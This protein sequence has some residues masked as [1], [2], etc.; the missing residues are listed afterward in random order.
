MTL[1][2][3]GQ[4]T[5]ILADARYNETLLVQS[6][7]NNEASLP[8]I[9]TT[10]S[11][12][13][14]RTPSP[15]SVGGHNLDDIVP[16]SEIIDSLSERREPNGKTY[17]IDGNGSKSFENYEEANAVAL[18]DDA[19]SMAELTDIEI[20][21]SSEQS[22]VTAQ[23][24]PQ[25]MEVYD[26]ETENAILQNN[27]VSDDIVRKENQISSFV[28]P[29][30]I[31]YETT[32]KKD[33]PVILSD[34]TV[35]EDENKSESAENEEKNKADLI[36]NK[37]ENTK[38]DLIIVNEPEE[39]KNDES[40]L[41]EIEQNDEEIQAKAIEAVVADA[42]NI[43]LKDEE[44]MNDENS[45]K[46]TANEFN[47]TPV[48]LS[49]T[50][51][52]LLNETG[53]GS[54]LIKKNEETNTE[55][56]DRGNI[57]DDGNIKPVDSLNNEIV[58]HN[59]KPII[60]KIVPI[61]DVQTNSNLSDVDKT[62]AQ[63]VRQSTNTFEENTDNVAPLSIR[64]KE[65]KDRLT[66]LLSPDNHFMPERQTYKKPAS[67]KTG[68][69]TPTNELPMNLVFQDIR[70]RRE[71][72]ETPTVTIPR[73]KLNNRFHVVPSPTTVPDAPRFNTEL[74]NGV[75]NGIQRLKSVDANKINA[76]TDDQNTNASVVLRK[77]SANSG[78][79]EEQGNRMT[80]RDK[81]EKILQRGPQERF[82]RPPTYFEPLAVAAESKED[83]VKVTTPNEEP[84]SVAFKQSKKPFDTVHK[85]KIL[86]DD[87]LK[88]I[89]PNARASVL[90]KPTE[91][92]N[93]ND[94]DI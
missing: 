5:T 66:A 82:S 52:S 19:I 15:S 54:A 74:Y 44:I 3:D 48:I 47:T 76:L 89:T 93:N 50:E 9:I 30:P 22:T 14:T 27:A 12:K 18:I 51:P 33:T 72:K 39:I 26:A 68:I 13:S 28:A 86:F 75:T 17:F 45:N 88:S 79:D 8:K 56:I 7:C 49:A 78:S 4:E 24:H 11:E 69:K 21:S 2:S 70:A 42:K 81:L 61:F 23:I 43:H 90:H 60:P 55:D 71:T 64:S 1:S 58:Q 29:V 57:I 40:S 77:S 85:Q 65:F 41:K 25:I 63:I 32:I 38:T 87:V 73:A 92:V 46:K 35:N 37:E 94:N 16:V 67:E 53:S 6:R 91:H 10:P 83:N 84:E 59:G 80:I 31:V 20:E 62:P 34:L 36:V